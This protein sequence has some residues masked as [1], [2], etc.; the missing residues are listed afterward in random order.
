MAVIDGHV[1]YKDCYT[2]YLYI[3]I[4]TIVYQICRNFAY[5]FICLTTLLECYCH[6][7]D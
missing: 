6:R 1:V 4:N 2:K 3:Y 5:L 7:G